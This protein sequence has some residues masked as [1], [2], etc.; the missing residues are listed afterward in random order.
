MNSETSVPFFESG[1]FHSPEEVAKL[2]RLPE[3]PEQIPNILCFISPARSG[4]TAIGLL[5]AGHQEV[6][7]SYFQPFKN[8]LRH[9]RETIIYPNDQIIMMKETLGPMHKEELFDPI[10]FLLEAGIPPEKISTIIIGLRNPV[11]TMASLDHFVPGGMDVEYFARMQQYIIDLFHNYRQ[12][13]GER[14]IPF[15]YSLLQEAE[16]IKVINALLR[17]TPLKVAFETLEF[18]KKALGL[19]EDWSLDPNA[20]DS[21]MIWGEALNETYFKEAVWPTTK[22]GSFRY[23]G[24]TTKSSVSLPSWKAEMVMKLCQHSFNQF[25]KLAKSELGL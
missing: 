14:V 16:E 10:K 15:S 6:S 21:K 5:L 24:N 11:D 4:S 22:Q 25:H 9:G 18:N 12:S 1:R 3:N 2:I 23:V 13:M 7:R 17:K 8:G 20:K 19:R